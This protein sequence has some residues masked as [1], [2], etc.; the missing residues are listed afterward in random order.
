MGS[1]AVPPKE[2]RNQRG[3]AGDS[4]VGLD[5]V[6]LQLLELVQTEGRITLSE[7]GRR[8]RMSPAAVGERIRRLE[9]NGTITGY[10]AVVA[11]ER[12]GYGIQAFV[13]VSPHAG[14]T[15]CHFRSQDL[16]N[17]PEILEVHHV[18]GEDCWI[19]KI[20]VRNTAHLEE[21]L[22]KISSVGRTTTSIV[23]SSPV[24]RRILRPAAG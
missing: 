17:R 10:T 22:E 14:I 19:L 15:L 6:D 4:S 5:T 2:Q 12:L 13:R 24:E 11:P 20:A 18:I 3:L 7:L 8:V 9:A 21:L 16:I 23:L 1:W